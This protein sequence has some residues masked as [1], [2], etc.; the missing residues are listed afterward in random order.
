MPRILPAALVSAFSLALASC[1]GGPPVAAEA[2]APVQAVDAKPAPAPM[3]TRSRSRQR[4]RI[5]ARASTRLTA[6]P[7]MTSR[8]PRALRLQ[9]HAGDDLQFINFALTGAGKC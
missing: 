7:A 1:Q 4:R 9:G 2:P 6:Q 8:K 3:P 5:R